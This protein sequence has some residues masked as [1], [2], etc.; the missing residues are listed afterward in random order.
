MRVLAGLAVFAAI[1]SS[2]KFSWLLIAAVFAA[3]EWYTRTRRVSWPVDVQNLLAGMR[4]AEPTPAQP[5]TPGR[6]GADAPITA[7]IPFRPLTIPDI[8]GGAFKVVAR[9]WPTLVGIPVI[10]LLG[11]VVYVVVVSFVLFT[12]FS[13]A[14]SPLLGGMFMTTLES[15]NLVLLTIVVMLVYMAVVT[16]LALPADALLIATSVIATD[17]AVRGEPVRVGE[18][19]GAARAHMFP[20]CR[21][22]LVFYG[23]C[24]APD[25]IIGMALF[26]VGIT[27]ML[28]VG[29]ACVV[30][31]F[32]IGILLSLSPIVLIVEKRGVSASLKR[33]MQLAKPAWGRLL[34]IHLLWAVSATVLMTMSWLPI[35]VFGP[36][37]FF[38]PVLYVVALPFMISYFRSLQM[39]IYTDLRIRQ[40]AYDR[41]L[42]ADWTRN[43][44]L[45]PA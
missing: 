44:G 40:E 15:G 26:T 5:Q 29:L 28:L 34:G 3:A 6:P 27:G 41:E 4:L 33:S 10:I 20:A 7:V 38:V 25:I 11:F 35:L 21:L 39:L 36:L 9:N 32:I 45:A 23:I 24:F 17:K 19:F 22:T 13:E 14:L 18:V 37:A 43:T 16:A 12:I 30:G 42:L 8:F 2:A 31:T 1:F